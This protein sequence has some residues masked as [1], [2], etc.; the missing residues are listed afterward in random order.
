MSTRLG[1]PLRQG[2]IY[3]VY[4]Y[5]SIFV[6]QDKYTLYHRS[7]INIQRLELR[8]REV[9]LKLKMAQAMSDLG[10]TGFESS[11]LKATLG[12]LGA[13]FSSHLI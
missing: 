4:L 1:A 6:S 3:P 2:Q 11:V 5:H 13:Y 8:L 7:S 9:K 10:S 12:F